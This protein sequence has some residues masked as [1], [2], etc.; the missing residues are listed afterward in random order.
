MHVWHP[1][2][3]FPCGSA[4]KESACSAG[5]LGSNPGLG[6]SPGE[7]KGYPRQYSGPENS[8]DCVVHGVAKSQTRLSNFHFSS[9][10]LL[11]FPQAGLSSLRGEISSLGTGHLPEVA[12]VC[13]CPALHIRDP[14]MVFV[15]REGPQRALEVSESRTSTAVAS[16]WGFTWAQ[17]LLSH[18][19]NGPVT[20][21]A[22]LLI[23][24]HC[25]G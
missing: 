5:D 18:L 14:A 25:L 24:G 21:G 9:V 20:P 8:L 17:P 13:L 10:K 23:L 15:G 3:S 6:R 12:S 19:A 11:G 22:R 1:L 4:G 2:L 7:G 16:G